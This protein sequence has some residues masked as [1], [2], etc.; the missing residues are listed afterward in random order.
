MRAMRKMELVGVMMILASCQASKVAT[1][2]DQ[3]SKNSNSEL[4][5]KSTMLSEAQQKIWFGFDMQKDSIPGI[6]LRETK[7]FLNDKESTGA[8]VAI[9]DS[10]IEL[11]HPQLADHVWRNSDEIASNNQDDD[12]NGYI[13]DLNGWNFLGDIYFAPLEVTRIVAGAKQNDRLEEARSIVKS[14]SEELQGFLDQYG[15]A[16]R[17]G[18][19]PSGFLKAYEYRKVQSDY[20]YN[21][22]FDP[23]DVL[24]DNPHDIAD[25]NYGNNKVQN[26]DEEELHGTHVAGI[27]TQIIKE[28]GA[29]EITFMPIRS[30]PRG[31]EYDKDV[32]LA[33]RYAVDNGAKVINMSFGKAFSMYPEMVYEAIEYAESKDVLLVHAAGNNGENVDTTMVYPNDH[34]GTDKEIVDNFITVG[35]INRY[36][37]ETLIPS[38][39]NY[40]FQNVDIF[41]PGHD[42]YSSI[43]GNKYEYQRGTSMAAPMVSAVAALIRS[44]YPKL[45]AP[46]VKQIIMESGLPGPEIIWLEGGDEILREYPFTAICKSGRIL[47]AYNALK[48]ADEISK[49]QNDTN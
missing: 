21:T 47:N 34:R 19:A 24:E 35:A 25:T 44:Y 4:V 17:S 37:N 16:Y 3:R 39:T 43:P 9:L 26:Q 48:M 27:F 10:G 14:K 40:G 6:S 36:Y 42:I 22:A 11:H 23:R 18:E 1:S 29:G 41:A 15:P 46:Q 7:V 33:I 12:Q 20:H 31:D 38:F 28:V 5:Y 45:T 30:T 32:A 2:T 13:D 49:K 8:I